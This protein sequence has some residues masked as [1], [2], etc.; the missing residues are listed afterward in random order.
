MGKCG[1]CFQ[2]LWMRRSCE[3]GFSSLFFLSFMFWHSLSSIQTANR[4][5]RAVENTN[6]IIILII[7][8]YESGWK[9]TWLFRFMISKHLHRKSQRCVE[10]VFE[11]QKEKKRKVQ[12]FWWGHVWFTPACSI[13]S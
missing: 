2:V 9:E 5:F 12:T 10:K 4:Q 7:I 11:I 8:V 3:M 1:F 13:Q 6:C